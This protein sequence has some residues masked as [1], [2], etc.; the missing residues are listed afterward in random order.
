M[1]CPLEPVVQLLQELKTRVPK[2][3]ILW[4][5][6]FTTILAVLLGVSAYS[7]Q[8]AYILS[9]CLIGCFV[10]F[11]SRLLFRSS[12]VASLTVIAAVSTAVGGVLLASGSFY[13]PIKPTA[14]DLVDGGFRS[15]GGSFVVGSILGY[16]FSIFAILPYAAVSGWSNW[17][18]RD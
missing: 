6:S 7:L 5:F 12:H 1:V 16:C 18:G 10:G 2:F 8:F 9:C 4:L 13:L 3:T 11:A 14:G 17:L 15:A